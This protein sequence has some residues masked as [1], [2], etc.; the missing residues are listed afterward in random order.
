MS[1]YKQKWNVYICKRFWQTKKKHGIYFSLHLLCDRLR[2]YQLP[3]HKQT[4]TQTHT[5]H[6]EKHPLHL[7]WRIEFVFWIRTSD[8]TPHTRHTIKYC[9]DYFSLFFFAPQ[10]EW[11]KKCSIV[12]QCTPSISLCGKLRMRWKT[13]WNH[14]HTNTD[15]L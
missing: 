8:Q 14:T 7:V 2:F 9:Y 13:H 12:F 6:A 1:Y 5:I 4:S 11:K 15:G 3:R 10:T